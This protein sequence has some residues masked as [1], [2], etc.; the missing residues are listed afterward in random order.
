[1]L[2]LKFATDVAEVRQRS[3]FTRGWACAFLRKR[4]IRWPLVLTES[5]FKNGKKE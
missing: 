3:F 5:S 1:M 2:K 4:E